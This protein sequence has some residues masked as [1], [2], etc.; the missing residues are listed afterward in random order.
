MKRHL[1]W[2]V[3][4]AL[5]AC[6]GETERHADSAAPDSTKP[7]VITEADTTGPEPVEPAFRLLGTEPFW[8]LQI[9][10]V[11]LRF[12]TPE[13][14][15]GQVFGATRAVLVGDSLRWNS[16]GD[17]GMIEA[18]VA[19]EQCSDGMSDKTWP[20]RARVVLG[21]TTYTGCAEKQ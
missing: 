8:N 21:K 14:T 13:D 4:V 17:A 6:A 12:R 1:R 18:V 15:A 9:D 16:V 3:G 11:G 5:M 19:P 20:Y 7:D 2:I 10:S